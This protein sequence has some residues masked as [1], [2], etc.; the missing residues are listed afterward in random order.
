M[1]PLYYSVYGSVPG[2]WLNLIEIIG[3]LL[4]LITDCPSKYIV[5]LT[6]KMLW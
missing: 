2:D 1:S 3:K 6:V 5:P 4:L